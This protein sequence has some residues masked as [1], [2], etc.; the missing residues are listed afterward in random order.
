MNIMTDIVE[1]ITMVAM[2]LVVLGLVAYIIFAPYFAIINF[3]DRPQQ[4]YTSKPQR[5]TTKTDKNYSY[6][7]L[8]CRSTDDDDIIKKRYR[9]LVKKYHPDFTQSK[10]GD[11]SSMVFAKRRIQEINSAYEMIKRERGAF[12]T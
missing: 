3:I 9:E 8:G 12:E 4:R 2:I 7:I 6:E 10:G 11:K 1:V 5:C